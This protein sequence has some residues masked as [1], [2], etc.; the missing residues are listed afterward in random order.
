MLMA[1]KVLQYNLQGMNRWFDIK[2]QTKYFGR[3]FGSEKPADDVASP[4][5]LEDV[6]K[7]TSWMMSW[8]R[9]E[10]TLLRNGSN[11]FGDK[12]W[13]DIAIF[14]DDC[15]E[16]EGLWVLQ[17]MR[18]YWMTSLEHIRDTE[19]SW[20]HW[21]KTKVMIW[22]TIGTMNRQE[23]YPTQTSRWWSESVM[24]KSNLLP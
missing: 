20:Y 8:C 19:M 10:G 12:M 23:D 18:N 11:D 15:H 24:F 16:N 14:R 1:L 13:L 17:K 21:P 2:H 3:R 4:K 7:L 9:H 6:S 22:W 5:V